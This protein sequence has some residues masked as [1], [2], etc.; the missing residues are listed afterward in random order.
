MGKIVRKSIAA[1][2]MTASLTAQSPA[3]PTF[4]AASIK[5]SPSSSGF[6]AVRV[7]GDRLVAEDATLRALIQFAYQTSDDR[8]FLTSQIV[9]SPR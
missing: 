1:A 6:Q 4:D 3:R 9:D 2:L 8:R 5:P 7:V